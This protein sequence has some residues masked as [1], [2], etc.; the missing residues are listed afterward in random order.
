MKRT[1]EQEEEDEWNEVVVPKKKR[2]KKKK[3]GHSERELEDMKICLATLLSGLIE[4]SR[5]TNRSTSKT[6][7][8]T[9]PD[10]VRPPK[11]LTIDHIRKITAFF[12][13]TFTVRENK[14]LIKLPRQERIPLV[15]A[16]REGG[17]SDLRIVFM[18]IFDTIKNPTR[19]IQAFDMYTKTIL[20]S[21]IEVWSASSSQWI[22]VDPMRNVVTRSCSEML[23]SLDSVTHVVA[24][25][26]VGVFDRSEINLTDVTKT[27][28]RS[29]WSKC[30]KRRLWIES[31]FVQL[32]NGLSTGTSSSSHASTKMTSNT[33][34][35]TFPST[36]DITMPS[37]MY[38]FRVCFLYYLL[39]H[40]RPFSLFKHTHS[41]TDT[42]DTLPRSTFR[43]K[44]HHT[45]QGQR[46]G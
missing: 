14:D 18:S 22:A 21:W 11:T 3:N 12:Y 26:R 46:K 45:R 15:V 25:E 16:L 19:L 33:E 20:A 31:I 8:E 7:F 44:P 32:L 27:Y 13:G 30:R 36:N 35:K 40:L 4:D 2:K 37:T 42:S 28:V 43:S 6:A 5:G 1:Q 23:P 17:G 9:L 10:P 24:A 38:A 34:T 41:Q 39:Y 29:K